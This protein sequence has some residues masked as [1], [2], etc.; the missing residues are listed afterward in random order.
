MRNQ[1][2]LGIV[3]ALC[4]VGLVGCGTTSSRGVVVGNVTGDLVYRSVGADGQE[5]GQGFTFEGLTPL[6]LE[7]M[8]IGQ[9]EAFLQA[10]SVANKISIDVGTVGGE[11][12]IERVGSN[13]QNSKS[14]EIRTEKEHIIVGELEAQLEQ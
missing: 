5:E 6:Q 8:E 1:A 12:R 4:V 10:Q 9:I 11:M 14:Y 7:G 2:W 3:L 13:M